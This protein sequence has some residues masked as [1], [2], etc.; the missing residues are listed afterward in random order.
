[1]T[2]AKRC[3]GLGVILILGL[4]MVG[5]ETARFPKGTQKTEPSLALRPHFTASDGIELVAYQWLPKEKANANILLLHG[6]NE[7]S[8]AF[9]RVGEYFA[10]QGLRVFAID[11]RGFGRSAHRGLWSSSERMAEDAREMAKLIHDVEPDKPLVIV[12]TSMGGAVGLLAAGTGPVAA[13]GLA[14]VA[15]AVWTRQTQP[16]YQRWALEIAKVV[17]PS[18]SPTGESLNIRPTDNIEML[19]EIWQSPWMISGGSRIDTVDGLVNLMDKA[20]AAAPENKVPTLLLYGKKDELVPEQ[21][22]NLLWERLPKTMDSKQ[23]RYDNGWHMLL[24][25]LQGEKVMDDIVQWIAQL[26]TA[27]A[28]PSR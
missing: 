27:K 26:Q 18:W 19:R 6:F 25:D 14:L 8:G 21:P 11:Q 20:F 28:E 3:I 22:I 15:P 5:C 23:I 2:W 24:R 12:G 1:M 4:Y 13:D 7:Y 10:K 9:N 17:A 16:F